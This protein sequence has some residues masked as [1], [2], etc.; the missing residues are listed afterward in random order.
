MNGFR[1]PVAMLLNGAGAIRFQVV[2]A[3]LMGLS[4]TGLSI[5]LVRAVGISGVIYGTL[6]A[7]LC[8]VVIPSLIYVPRLLPRLGLPSGVDDA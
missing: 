5:A 6:L 8:F 7:E 1:G 4:N 2:M 3:V